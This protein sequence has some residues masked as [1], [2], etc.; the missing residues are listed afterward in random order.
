MSMEIMEFGIAPHRTKGAITLLKRIQRAAHARKVHFEFEVIGDAEKPRLQDYG[1]VFATARSYPKDILV[2][3]WGRLSDE[4]IAK[5]YNP[6]KMTKEQ[7]QNVRYGWTKVPFDKLTDGQKN[8]L[9]VEIRDG[10][11]MYQIPKPD[12]PNPYYDTW[13]AQKPDERSVK[14][15]KE[16]TYI[17]G[18]FIDYK[19][20][21]ITQSM[22]AKGDWSKDFFLAPDAHS[23]PRERMRRF[24]KAQAKATRYVRREVSIR[25]E[26]GLWKDSQWDILGT[27]EPIGEPKPNC[28]VVHRAIPNISPELDEVFA[29]RAPQKWPKIG[30][31]HCKTNRR[32]N[33]LIIV[34]HRKK[35]TVKRVATSCV[36]EYCNIDP[37]LIEQ[38]FNLDR[39]RLAPDMPT[40]NGFRPHRKAMDLPDFMTI[41]MSA[42]AVHGEYKKGLGS[43]VFG[44]QL[45]S[46]HDAALEGWAQTPPDWDGDLFLGY[47]EQGSKWTKKGWYCQTPLNL[48][49]DPYEYYPGAA[50]ENVIDAV[51]EFME[52]TFARYDRYGNLKIAREDYVL[53][54]KKYEIGDRRIDSSYERNLLAI[55]SAGVVDKKSANFAASAFACYKRHME[56]LWQKKQE[57][58]K[59]KAEKKRAYVAPADG[60]LKNVVGECV[61]RR[62]LS[63]YYS[64]I[65]EIDT[66]D[67][68][69]KWFGNRKG[70]PRIELGDTV[71]ILTGK[72]K[73]ID[74][75]PRGSG[76]QTLSINYV[77]W[78]VDA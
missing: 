13:L 49:G 76:N 46:K 16:R 48:Y 45:V 37:K 52:H 64:T 17:E 5:R 14:P 33:K 62:Y 9:K 44:R 4:E 27:V 20:A 72:K 53:Q 47:Y 24:T 57:A 78:E 70:G 29:R 36:F 60:K 25:V 51:L 58:K 43:S 15:P 65:Y 61:A 6:E 7:I 11:P 1:P 63:D 31:Q 41:A 18:L 39:H 22:K 19:G 54:G 2:R 32:R 3:A 75:W 67:G 10:A 69:I 35:G 56:V 73:G 59:P 34:R 74:E 68:F 50:T 71:T 40:S 42:C 23:K 38:L 55:F 26:H 77:K 8:R 30:C 12:A 28:P 66:G 21:L